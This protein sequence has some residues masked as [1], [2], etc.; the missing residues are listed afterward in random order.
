MTHKTGK[1]SHLMKQ[2]DHNLKIYEKAPI[3]LFYAFSPV[4]KGKK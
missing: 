1:P 4:L 3:A 2:V